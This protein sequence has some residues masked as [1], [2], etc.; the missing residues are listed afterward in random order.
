MQTIYKWLCKRTRNDPLTT[1]SHCNCDSCL[2]IKQSFMNIEQVHNSHVQFDCHDDINPNGIWLN[3]KGR[4]NYVSWNVHLDLWVFFLPLVIPPLIA[5]AY[6]SRHTSIS[7]WAYVN[8]NRNETKSE[9]KNRL[10]KHVNI[11]RRFAG[12][13]FFRWSKNIIALMNEEKQ[14]KKNLKNNE[15][16]CYCLNRY[17]SSSS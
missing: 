9:D 5:I 14:K 8:Q 16:S 1:V 4:S 7:D 3:R 15:S 13:N 17:F 12:T 11:Q 10:W 2:F 6:R